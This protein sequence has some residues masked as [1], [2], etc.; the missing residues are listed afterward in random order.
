MLARRRRDGNRRDDGLR[1]GRARWRA[2]CC[3][4]PRT[5]ALPAALRHSTMPAGTALYQLLPLCCLLF[6]PAEGASHL[7]ALLDVSLNA[8]RLGRFCGWAACS[9]TAGG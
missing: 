5:T 8:R 9:G 1:G 7:F 6:A 4:L 2:C 3:R